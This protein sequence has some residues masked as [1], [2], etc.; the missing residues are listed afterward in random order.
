[1]GLSSLERVM[2]INRCKILEKLYPEEA[3]HYQRLN[4][5]LERGYELHYD[6]IYEDLREEM[7]A[8]ECTEG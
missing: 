3:N 2:L 8:S 6:R 5:A 4:K 7:S 1:M